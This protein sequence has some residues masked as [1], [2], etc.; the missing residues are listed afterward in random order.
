MFGELK[1]YLNEQYRAEHPVI[2]FLEND[3]LY[4]FEVFSA[5]LTDIHDPAYQLDFTAP[6]SFE[7]FLERTG[8]PPDAE[9]VITLSTCV[10]ADNDRRMIRPE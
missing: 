6:G 10:G 8:A 3:S 1:N 5:I 2:M 7:G 9:Q 4:E